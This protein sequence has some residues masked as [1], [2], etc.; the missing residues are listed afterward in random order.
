MKRAPLVL[1]AALLLL[2]LAPQSGNWTWRTHGGVYGTRGISYVAYE[3]L[4]ADFGAVAENLDWELIRT[5]SSAPD[6]WKSPPYFADERHVMTYTKRRGGWWL[7]N[8]VRVAREAQAWDNAAYTMGIAAHY[9]GDV[10]CYPHHDNARRYYEER[11]GEEFGYQIWDGLHDHFEGQ[12]YYYQ[13]K[14]PAFIVRND[15]TPHPNLADFL[16][17]AYS[18][19][20]DLIN[21][22]MP[23]SVNPEVWMTG[24]WGQWIQTRKCADE[25][26][27]AG[28]SPPSGSKEMVNLAT[29]LVYSGWVYALNLQGDEVLVP[30]RV[31]WDQLYT[32]Y[33]T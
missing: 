31:T 29:T 23:P 14:S 16:N 21:N 25:G 3:A 15:G 13:P 24:W 28:I 30:R 2:A 12:V 9:W 6:E 22:V 8:G 27:Q 5:G 18:F 11:Y 4:K 32:Q 20:D 10:T 33:F 17:G 26:I 19:L 1:L 7:D